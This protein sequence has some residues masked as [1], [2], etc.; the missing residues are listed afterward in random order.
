MNLLG[1][2]TGVV[3]CA[4]S[5]DWMDNNCHVVP[6]RGGSRCDE[7][8]TVKANGHS[9]EDERLSGMANG[10]ADTDFGG[11]VVAS[12][13]AAAPARQTPARSARARA[14]AADPDGAPSST[15]MGD[16]IAIG[17]PVAAQPQLEAAGADHDRL[18]ARLRG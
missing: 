14:K 11:I 16:E 18:R 8:P 15:A 17:E 10:N 4:S 1:S 9:P 13:P 7:Q 12:P 6:S 3:P 2:G 5:I